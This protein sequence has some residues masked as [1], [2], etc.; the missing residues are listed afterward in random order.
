MERNRHRR[1]DWE[2]SPGVQEGNAAASQGRPQEQKRKEKNIMKRKFKRIAS[3]VLAAV[4]VF[5]M[6]MPA[7]ATDTVPGLGA[8]DGGLTGHT[9]VAYQIFKGE[10]GAAPE[11]EEGKGKPLGNIEWGDGIDEVGFLKALQGAPE[12]GTLFTGATTAA[13]VAKIIGDQNWADDSKQARAIAKLAYAH[14]KGDGIATGKNVDPG[15]Y[16]I[17]DTTNVAGKDDVANLA[18]LQFTTAGTFEATTKVDK[19]SVEKKVKEV[20][21]T[22]GI[23]SAWQD[24]ADYDIGDTIEFQLKGTLPSDFASYDTYEYQFNDTLSA[25]LTYTVGSAQVY[26]VDKGADLNADP[27]PIDGATNITDYFT[28]TP[29]P[30]GDDGAGGTLTL[31][32]KDLRTIPDISADKMIV[33]R[34]TAVLN[35]NATVGAAGNLNSVNLEYSNNPNE[36]GKGKTPDDEVKVFTY[37]LEVKKVDEN[38]KSLSGAEFTLTKKN[39][40][41]VYESLK[42]SVKFTISDDGTVFTWEGLDEGDYKLEE[43]KTPAGYNTIEPIEFTIESNFNKDDMGEDREAPTLSSLKA[44]ITAPTSMEDTVIEAK[45]DNLTAGLI[46]TEVENKQGTTLP[47]T[48]GIGTTIFY[49]VGSVL[50]LGAV[51]LLVTKRR[52]KG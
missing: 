17:V 22:R 3:L 28:I 44:T 38:G 48:G 6:A 9:F 4:M 16:L 1:E 32:C 37:K 8:S 7:M 49:V 15:Y 27:D 47:E 45:G 30:N 18:L 13:Q 21:D 12:I 50:V 33:V 24:G 2:R 26:L 43:T 46:S 23:T 35:A 40:D 10:Q 39:A 36:A 20:N 29:A 14:K 19:P 42:E 34:Y 25:G 51:I 41:N 52:M 11:S 5:A 31:F